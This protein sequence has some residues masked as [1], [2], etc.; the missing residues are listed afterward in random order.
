MRNITVAVSDDSYR[1]ARIWAAKNET[2]V[3][4]VVPDL[5]HNLPA[6]ARVARSSTA[7]MPAPAPTPGSH[8]H[9]NKRGFPAVKLWRRSQ[10]N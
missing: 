6:L 8:P 9:E 4:A 5:L 2:S 1:Q 3:S 7:A 10:T